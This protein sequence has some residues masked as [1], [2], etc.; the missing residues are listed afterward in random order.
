MQTDTEIKQRGQP[1]RI[2]LYWKAAIG[3]GRDIAL[4]EKIFAYLDYP[5][6]QTYKYKKN[7]LRRG[8]I[9]NHS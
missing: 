7:F 6:H 4:K 1:S 5:A 3:I 9:K 2:S 8:I